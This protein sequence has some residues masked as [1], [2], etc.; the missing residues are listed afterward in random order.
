MCF[1]VPVH[2]KAATYS[3]EY[4]YSV[5]MLN[6]T[7]YYIIQVVW[8]SHVT[9]EMLLCSIYVDVVFGYGSGC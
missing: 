8:V 5:L 4:I 7:K 2:F 9:E 1:L 6:S 3:D